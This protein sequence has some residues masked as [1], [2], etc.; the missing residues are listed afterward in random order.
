MG[1]ARVRQPGRD[2]GPVGGWN[3]KRNRVQLVGLPG[4][5]DIAV[6]VEG[7]PRLDQGTLSH[8]LP[9]GNF[10]RRQ[11]L[12]LLR[13]R[14]H[15]EKFRGRRIRQRRDLLDVLLDL[16]QRGLGQPGSAAGGQVIAVR[17]R[18]MGL[19]AVR[20]NIGAVDDVCDLTGRAAAPQV[21]GNAQSELVFDH[22]P[23]Q[24]QGALSGVLI[25]AASGS[26]RRAAS[27]PAGSP[28]ARSGSASG[29]G[30]W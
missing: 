13:G 24:R 15:L 6:H 28:T 7:D 21:S 3:Q 9:D 20:D 17:C 5:T 11:G 1:R 26:A 4:A 12:D 14:R 25:T 27:R 8:L 16:A 18:R 2:E 30:R 29:P 23:G 10:A 22:G 19:G